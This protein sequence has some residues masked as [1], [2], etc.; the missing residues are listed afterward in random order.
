VLDD[1]RVAPQGEM[2]PVLFAGA[3]GHQEP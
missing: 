3:H 2:G 1:D